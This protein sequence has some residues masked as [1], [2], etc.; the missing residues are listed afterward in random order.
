L[1][2]AKVLATLRDRNFITP[3]DIK[4]TAAPI[5]RHRLILKPE[6]EIEGVPVDQVID[7]ILASVEV[8][9]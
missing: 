2:A 3:D 1:Q 7:T 4:E 8:P 6:A 5:L 9:R